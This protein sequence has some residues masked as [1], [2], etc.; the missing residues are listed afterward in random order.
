MWRGKNRSNCYII[1]YFEMVILRAIG[2]MK[3]FHLLTTVQANA[4]CP[5]MI[6]DYV[7][8]ACALVNLQP[9]IRQSEVEQEN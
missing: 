7:K 1:Q 4:T 9:C 2:R 8:I 3:E 5:Q 6:D